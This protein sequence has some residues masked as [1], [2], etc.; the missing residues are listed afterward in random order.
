MSRRA[1]TARAIKGLAAGPDLSARTPPLSGNLMGDNVIIHG[2]GHPPG[3]KP[4]CMNNDAVKAA[5][6]RYANVYDALFGPVLQRGRKAVI[7]ALG[8]RP[9]ERILEVGVGTGLSL[10][11]YPPGVEV[12][13][14]DLSAEMLER[15]RARVV[16]QKLTHVAGLYEMNAEEM[17]FPDGTFDKVVAMYVVSVVENPQRLLRELHRVCAPHGE[18]LLV[19]HVLSDNPLLGAV[20]RSLARFSEKLGFRPDFQLTDLVNGSAR[21]ETV[22]TVNLLWKVMRVRNGIDP[23]HAAPP[24]ALL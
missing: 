11:I 6:A 4:H 24:R 13:G 3:R 18:I 10:P 9:G 2:P 12:T 8:C 19:N 16:R 7:E 21:I 17:T 1:Q 5:Y 20:E 15:A 23:A 14:I 22:A